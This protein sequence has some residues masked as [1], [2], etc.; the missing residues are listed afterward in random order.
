MY[1]L[2]FFFLINLI[3]LKFD[4][5]VQGSNIIGTKNIPVAETILPNGKLK[6]DSEIKKRFFFLI[7]FFLF[8]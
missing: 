4:L 5:V 8:N 2:L 6:T 1:L 7:D 3:I